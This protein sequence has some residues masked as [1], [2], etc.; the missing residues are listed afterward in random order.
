MT[1]DKQRIALTNLY[2]HATSIV[3]YAA[4]LDASP[5]FPHIYKNLLDDHL[6][7][8]VN[9]WTRY[10][11]PDAVTAKQLAQLIMQAQEEFQRGQENSVS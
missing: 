11:E 2:Y 8:L 4:M 9:E 5:A 7:K 10:A 6:R 1:T 3:R